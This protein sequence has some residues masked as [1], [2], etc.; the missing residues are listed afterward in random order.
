[1]EGCKSQS[2]VRLDAIW[3]ATGNHYSEW[4][5]W[6]QRQIFRKAGLIA[7][8]RKGWSGEGRWGPRALRSSDTGEG[9]GEGLLHSWPHPATLWQVPVRPRLRSYTDGQWQESKMDEKLQ[10]RPEYCNK[11]R[12]RVLEEKGGRR[13]SLGKA[14]TMWWL[15]WLLD[16]QPQKWSDQSLVGELGMVASW[17]QGLQPFIPVQLNMTVITGCGTSCPTVIS[18]TLIKMKLL[19]IHFLQTLIST[20]SRLHFSHLP[21]G[22]PPELSSH[23]LPSGSTKRIVSYQNKFHCLFHPL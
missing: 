13:D 3:S 8:S 21:S 20:Q 10:Q 17:G 7:A 2:G 4:K 18:V 11:G 12:C 16:L 22:S 19:L 23:V 5:T 15:K 9:E 14:D 6:C 1:M